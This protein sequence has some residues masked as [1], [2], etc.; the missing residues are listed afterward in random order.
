[1]R[2]RFALLAAATT[3]LLV[4]HATAADANPEKTRKLIAVLQSNASFFDK[5][6]S[7]QQLGEFGD[8]EAV[9]ALAALLA[10]EHL[11]AYARSGL[12]GIPDPS[13]AEALRTAAGTLQGSRL[14]GMINSLGVLRDAK[15]V[16]LLRRLAGDPK[17]GVVKE[18]VLALGRIATEESLQILRQAL[19]RGPEAIRADAAAACLLAA[20]KQLADGHTDTA[21]ALYDAVRQTN[22][23]PSYRAAATRG[24]IV[25]RKA[26]GVPLLI[27][28]LGSKDRIL[29]NAAL[30]S[31]REIPSD[32]LAS[33]LNAELNRGPAELQ[34]QLLTALVDCHNAQSLQVLQ[35]KVASDD[36]EIRRT[37]L[38]VMGRIGGTAEAG[39]LLKAVADNRSAE[40]AAIA[41]NGL[42]QMEGAI[43]DQQIAKALASTADVGSR[44]QF[45]RLLGG[46]GATNAVGELIQQAADPDVKVSVA[47]L[48]ALKSL[49]GS[50]ELAALIGLARTCRDEIVR[51]AAENAVVG[52]CTRTGNRALGS[53][54]ALA[55]LKQTTDPVVKNSWIRILVSFG[56]A[57]TLPP[58]LAALNDPNESVAANA[59]EQ[60]ARWPDPTPIDD[61]FAVVQ[62]GAN[63]ARRSRALASVI[64][65]ATTAADEHQRPAET[66]VKWFQRASQA[67]QT[68]EERRLIISGLGR[69]NHIES[70]RLLAPY[71][72]DRGLQQEAALAIVQIAPAL[73]QADPAALKDAL[74]KIA[75]TAAS[76]DLRRQAGKI[77]GTIPKQV[78]RSLL[79]DGRSLAGW[80]GNTNVWR[81]R[82][83]V[84]VGG[85]MHGNPR[86]EFLATLQRY[87]NFILRLE[88]RLA[89]T[90]GFVNGGVQFRSVRTQQPSNEMSGFQADLGPGYSGCLY[91]ESRR[92]KFLARP[93]GEQIKRLERPGDWNRY[94]VRCAGPRV[95]IALNGEKTVDYIEADAAMPQNGLIALQIHGDCKAEISFRN[96]SIQ[97]LSYGIA[98]R[99]FGLAKTRWKVQSFSSENTQAEDER[100]VLAIDGNPDTFWHTLWNGGSPGHP[101]HLAV[102][103]AEAVEITGFAYLPRQDGRH[104][105]GVIGEYEFQV[106]REGKEWSQPVAR[107]RFER[108]D[109]DANGRVVLLTRPVTARYFKL[110]S[111]SAPGNEPYAGAAEI[112]V[113]GKPVAR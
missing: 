83:G 24:A 79:F 101:H 90:E 28:Q 100:A 3:S 80:E 71:L 97:D 23:P 105:K 88:Y 15:A 50:A 12:E 58:I 87:S 70:F 103:L 111:R 77:A 39:V 57:K 44:I 68:M 82:D 31:I 55:E 9:P 22:L 48:G 106:S 91:D 73:R 86:N 38:T 85:S 104:V 75:S 84:I 45:I 51:E 53:E 4:A 110:V 102:D 63:P 98:T 66:V 81:V 29:R 40:E 27:E 30:L 14:A 94:E 99:D 96:L 47:A 109:L 35:A 108:I 41:V 95:Q 17:P 33:A 92:N 56:N 1:M 54:A 113:L 62:S 2:T 37:A 25:A 42:R 26:D 89:G 69:L 11:S 67:A 76:P 65:L 72:N 36:S 10:D 13:A 49:A 32:A 112:D 18:A 5:A 52:A 59:V 19:A 7:C 16:G 21:V 60:L 78:K 107:G 20:E 8:R 74:E 64:Q 6:R 46:R 34:I 61:L 43:V 93:S